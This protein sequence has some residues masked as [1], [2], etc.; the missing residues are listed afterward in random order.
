MPAIVV[1]KAMKAVS[2][3]VFFRAFG[4]NVED[5][6]SKKGALWL[7]G[8]KEMLFPFVEMAEGKFGIA[9]WYTNR[10]RIIGYNDGWFTNSDK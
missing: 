5:K 2:L 4:L 8:T 7:Y 1:E 6:R 3:L 10:G 9:G